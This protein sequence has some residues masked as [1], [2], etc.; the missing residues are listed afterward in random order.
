MRWLRGLSLLILIASALFLS[1]ESPKPR[2]T[3]ASQSKKGQLI[4]QQS[5]NSAGPTTPAAALNPQGKAGRPNDQPEDRNSNNFPGWWMIGLTAV[6]AAATGV[7]ACTARSIYRLNKQ[8]VIATHRPRIR[9]RTIVVSKPLKADQPIEIGF[10][11]VNVGG[12]DAAIVS[13]NFTIAIFAS[14][15]VPWRY[16]SMAPQPYDGDIHYIEQYLG[17]ATLKPGPEHIVKKA[18]TLSLQPAEAHD[19][20]ITSK[21]TLYALG[22]IYYRDD[23]G[24]HHK[25]AFCRRFS[26]GTGRFH[27]VIDSDLKYED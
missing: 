13:S 16:H 14:D 3:T 21:E 22:F 1:A 15:E 23:T 9:V 27:A 2:D 4:Q 19:I 12:T 25:T 11:V 18:R 5:K 7:Q 24:Q 8:L 17:Y 10:Y 26:I 20:V 6:I